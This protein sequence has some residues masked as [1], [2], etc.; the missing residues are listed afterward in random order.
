MKL[1]TEAD[2]DDDERLFTTLRKILD[3]NQEFMA[4]QSSIQAFNWL[5]GAKKS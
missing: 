3:V 2:G 4:I 1:V 5:F